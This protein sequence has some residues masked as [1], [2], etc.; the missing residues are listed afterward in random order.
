MQSA[1]EYYTCWY[2]VDLL[3]EQ[4]LSDHF[5]RYLFQSFD[6]GI[7]WFPWNEATIGKL[8]MQSNIEFHLSVVTS[9]QQSVRFLAQT[10]LLQL[11]NVPGILRTMR[12][13]QA[14]WRAWQ[15]GCNFLGNIETYPITVRLTG[16]IGSRVEG[17]RVYACLHTCMCVCVWEKRI[18]E[19]TTNFDRNWKKERRKYW[20]CFL[21]G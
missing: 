20:R 14:S 21:R 9:G 18:T 16:V 4:Q 12:D 1:S 8:C 13:T 2:E 15:A 17:A 19:P 3:M 10:E 5:D 11:I 6:G 7:T